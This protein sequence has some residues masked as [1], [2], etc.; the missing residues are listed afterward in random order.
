MTKNEINK[1]INNLNINNLY[2]CIIDTIT[3]KVGL[4]SFE[5]LQ[6][7]DNL[8]NAAIKLTY[9]I[10]KDHHLG[11]AFSIEMINILVD[12]AY[13][14]LYEHNQNMQ[15]ERN[16]A[17]DSLEGLLDKAYENGDTGLYD[18]LKNALK[19]LEG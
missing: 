12:E 7:F 2:D 1:N 11:D 10:L 17:L 15:A 4:T 8:S 5:D 19:A 16:Q 6:A 9:K 18:V 14:V 13:D 3:F